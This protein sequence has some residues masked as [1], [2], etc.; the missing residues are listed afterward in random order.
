LLNDSTR[1][2]V[3]NAK[4]GYL[5]SFKVICFDVD[6]NP[7]GTTCSHIIILVSYM[8]FAKI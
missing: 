2:T 8:N 7:L 1:K 4:Y 5:R 6:E 3:F